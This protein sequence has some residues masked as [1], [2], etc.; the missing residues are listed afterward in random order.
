MA[1]YDKVHRV[2]FGE[3]VPARALVS[4]VAD[5]SL[6]PEDAIAGHGPGMLATPAGPLGVVI[7]YEV[8]YDELARSAIRAGGEV[9][10]VPTNAAS[11]RTSQVPTQ[12]VAAS[13]LRAM[14][15]GRDV[16][17]ASPTGYSAFVDHNGKVTTRSG[18]G[19][20]QVLTG[21]V[22]LRTGQTIFVRFGG[23]PVLIASL[24]WLIVAWGALSSRRAASP[25]LT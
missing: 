10:L 11:Y 15:T 12:E 9:L 22:E 19:P 2:P 8:F 24:V 17:Q 21:T 7:S 25:R 16:V 6:I 5:L 20:A 18:L 3:Y 14:E 4:K 13:R 23:Q 1:R